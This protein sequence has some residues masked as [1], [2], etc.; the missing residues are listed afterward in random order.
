MPAD[1]NGDVNA[2]KRDHVAG[3]L[4]R[5][6]LRGELRPGD[7]LRELEIAEQL[8]VSQTPVREALPLLERE[9]LV[10]KVRHSGTYVAE[11]SPREL[12]ELLTLRAELEG[13]CARLCAGRASADDRAGL[14]EIVARMRAAADERDSGSVL[15]HDFAFHG[16]LYELGGH[17]LL[18]EDLLGLRRRMVLSLGLVNS[19][20]SSDLDDIVDSHLPILDA[21]EAASPDAADEAARAHVLAVLDSVGE[22]ASSTEGAATP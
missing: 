4:R 6:I 21:L 9:G 5:Q 12:Y 1:S 20:Y 2:I 14:R 10:R 11:L 17:R 16:A 7:R 13:Y 18:A 19:L 22:L 8:G 3:L 15:E